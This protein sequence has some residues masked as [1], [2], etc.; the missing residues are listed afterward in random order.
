MY[1]AE[2]GNSRIRT[3]YV[4]SP[5]VCFAWR[6]SNPE[7]GSTV[8]LALCCENGGSRAYFHPAWSGHTPLTT[9]AKKR[10]RGS[11]GTFARQPPARVN[12]QDKHPCSTLS[13]DSNPE[14]SRLN[15]GRAIGC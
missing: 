9:P 13:L 12:K 5:R 8:T 10:A 1:G 14:H 11:R 2:L 7:G 4:S 6:T 3:P 15:H